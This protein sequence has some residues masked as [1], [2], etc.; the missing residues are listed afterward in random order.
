MANQIVTLH[1]WSDTSRSFR[2]LVSFI[3]GLERAPSPH[4]ATRVWP[5]VIIVSHPYPSGARQL[6]NEDGGDGTVR[7]AAANLNALGLTVDFAR[8]PDNPRIE[9]W[10]HRH[11]DRWNPGR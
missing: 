2:P 9:R 8:D 5:F 1:G 4:G 11:G 10:R 3:E 6:V 7:V